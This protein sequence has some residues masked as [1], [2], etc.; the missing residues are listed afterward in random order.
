MNQRITDEA[1]EA[2]EYFHGA[3]MIDNCHGA[4]RHFVEAMVKYIAAAMNVELAPEE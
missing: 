1:F 2:L 4:Q 3:G